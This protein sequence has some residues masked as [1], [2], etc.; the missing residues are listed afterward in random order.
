LLIQGLYDRHQ[1]VADAGANYALSMSGFKLEGAGVPVADMFL[2]NL[3]LDPVIR[4]L[5]IENG[6][7]ITGR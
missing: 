7:S 5:L 6:Y 1:F 2:T 3:E 4:K